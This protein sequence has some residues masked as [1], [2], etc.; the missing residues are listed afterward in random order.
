M[1][2]VSPLSACVVLVCFVYYSYS[3]RNPIFV[4]PVCFRDGNLGMLTVHNRFFF[5]YMYITY[6][7][8]SEATCLLVINANYSTSICPSSCLCLPCLHC[9]LSGRCTPHGILGNCTVHIPRSACVSS[10]ATDVDGIPG[11][12]I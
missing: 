2:Q 12:V 7:M 11:E 4:H 3:L 8:V 1:W 6:G 10:A 9:L 5:K